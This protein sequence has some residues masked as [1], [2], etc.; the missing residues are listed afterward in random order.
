MR[1]YFAGGKLLGIDTLIWPLVS[2]LVKRGVT[3]T[4]SCE[5]H[6]ESSGEITSARV[7]IREIL[8]YDIA[9]WLSEQP[10]IEEV[11]AL[12]GREAKFPVMAVVIVPHWHKDFK[13][14]CHAVIRAYTHFALGRKGT[15]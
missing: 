13:R 10:G 8:R 1:R 15:P 12:W 7:W 9:Q 14:A 2:A 3:T 4:Q 5:G 6:R 11:A